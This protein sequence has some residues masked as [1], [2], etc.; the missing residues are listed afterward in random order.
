MTISLDCFRTGDGQLTV[1]ATGMHAAPSVVNLDTGE[2]VVLRPA[3]IETTAGI[4]FNIC[5]A[6]SHRANAWRG[7]LASDPARNEVELSAVADG[8]VFRGT[9]RWPVRQPEPAPGPRHR[10]R[11]AQPPR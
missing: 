2:A 8:Q 5:D 3:R 9:V 11:K 1:V 10:R 6:F 7:E 4:S